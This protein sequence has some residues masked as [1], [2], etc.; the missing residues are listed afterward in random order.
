[1]KLLVMLLIL[2]FCIGDAEAQ[3]T[4]WFYGTWNG[5]TY[6]PNGPITRRIIIK[7][8]VTS[9]SGNRFTA[10]LDNFYPNDTTV[11]LEREVAGTIANKN[12]VITSNEETYIRD[13]RT[14]NFWY[15]CTQCP[16]QSVFSIN[17]DK[18]EIK[19]TTINCGD[20]CNGETVFTRDTSDLDPAQKIQ[21]AKWLG[22]PANLPVVKEPEKKKDT[23]I[24][25]AKPTIQPA[26]KDSIITKPISRKD[27][28][29]MI[30]KPVKKDT[31]TIAATVLK[32]DTAVRPAIAQKDTVP[33]ALTDRTTN[34]IKTYQVTS[35]HIT[36]QL[37]DNAEI[38]GDIVSVYHN[39]KLIIDHQTL[40]HKAITLTINASPQ[41]RH[42]EF[43]MIAENLG[44]IPPNTAL[45]RI[46]A[47]GQKFEVEISSDFDN[48]AKIAID[49]IGE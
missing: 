45:M 40:T 49:Y 3:N 6:F 35:P 22:L 18:V 31:T 9:L 21:L 23:A 24:A 29:K 12:F 38:D 2:S 44:L 14:Q 20:V 15:D 37:Y 25:I 30:S 46:T 11:R 10:K 26:R 39:G 32:T 8:Q 42:H 36:I 43:V 1:M 33:N 7:L 4:S 41:S 48:N 13:P 27:T 5:E 47:G 28:A 34:L 17:S 16:M 19:I